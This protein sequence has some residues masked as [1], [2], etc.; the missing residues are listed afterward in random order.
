MVFC[1]FN[2]LIGASHSFVSVFFGRFFTGLVAS[3]PATVAFGNFDDM[4]DAKWRIWIV[5]IYTFCGNAGIVLGPI[6][7]SYISRAVGWRWIFYSKSQVTQ[8]DHWSD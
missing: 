8:K 2:V 5:Y 3:I 1:A 7:A 6:Y 4:F